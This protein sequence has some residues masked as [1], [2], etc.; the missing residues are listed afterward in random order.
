MI[1]EV[2]GRTIKIQCDFSHYTYAYPHNVS[3]AC[4]DAIREAGDITTEYV[5]TFDVL[6][7]L[8]YPS[9]ALQE[10]RLKQ[11]VSPFLHQQNFCLKY[12]STYENG[13]R[14]LR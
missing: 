3:D 1:S 12:L 8:C 11:M 7:D 9:T 4:N 2:V 13:F 10:L 14:L 5:N 6:P